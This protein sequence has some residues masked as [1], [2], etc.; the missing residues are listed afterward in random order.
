MVLSSVAQIWVSFNVEHTNQIFLINTMAFL[1]ISL[2]LK[3]MSE[4]ED[5]ALMISNP[6]I[7]LRLSKI[8][9]SAKEGFLLTGFFIW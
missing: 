5:T 2:Q 1:N 7:C 3:E 4:E 6:Q 8:M 9:K